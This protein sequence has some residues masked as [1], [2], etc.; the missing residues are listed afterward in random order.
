MSEE[1]TFQP[2]WGEKHEHRHHHHHSTGGG[3]KPGS[4]RA[5]DKQAFIGLVLV[6]LVAGAFAV[7]YVG[8]M[9]VN[10]LRSIPLDDPETEIN[11]D[12]L[13]IRKVEEQDAIQLGD[14]LAQEYNVDSLRRQV[15]IDT[16]APY[17]PP[18]KENTWYI[19]QREW[20]AMWKEFKI[21]RWERK[22]EKE[23]EEKE[24]R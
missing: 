8:K 10:E 21:M 2:H 16:R 24:S 1:K 6:I 3:P 20:K 15:Q 12:E 7:Y 9:I 19:T 23:K 17:R 18:K 5:K 22:R 11:V 13:R 4:L 14:S